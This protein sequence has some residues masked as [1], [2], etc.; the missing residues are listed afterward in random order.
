MMF[1]L[2]NDKYFYYGNLVMTLLIV[3]LLVALIFS[4]LC[5]IAEAVLLSVTAAH[6][7]ILEQQNKP[8]AALLK[9][10]KADINQPLAAI[11]SLNTIAHTVGAAGVGAQTAVVF[12]NAYLG[13]ASAVLTLLI[14]IFSEI[15][16]KTIGALYWRP[17]APVTAVLLNY[18]IRVLYPF[19]WLSNKITR[20]W[21]ERSLTGFSRDEFTAMA[22]LSA[23]EGQIADQES[24]MLKNLLLLGETRIRS[25]M[26]PRTVM[27]SVPE[28]LSVE[29]FI[30]AHN[31][32]QF[33]RILL[34]ADDKDDICGFVL[35]RDIL[36]AQTRGDSDKALSHYRREVAALPDQVSLL[37][38]FNEMLRQRAQIMLVVNEYGTI[39]GI[40][41]MEDLF[42]T[43]LGLE[44]I[45]EHD[46]TV[47]MQAL[48]REIWKDR[49]RKKGIE[50]DGL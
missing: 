31:Q 44:I 39:D 2:L 7:A 21:G 47:N 45:D 37:H 28:N 3:Y 8:S 36:L 25:A 46:K 9:T 6:I 41:T 16:P 12:G 10:L 22:D 19:V 35:H 20:G 24:R 48:A 17:L 5:S 34:Y 1:I 4:F 30:T 15:I 50:F 23:K 49:A 40:I 27:F 43:L 32:V 42:E 18:L 14:L 11:L 29:G 26:T 33:S 38:A 13:I